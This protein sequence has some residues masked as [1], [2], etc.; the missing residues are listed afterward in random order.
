[1]V[2]RTIYIDFDG[3]L[4]SNTSGYLGPDVIPDPPVIDPKTGRTAI[5]WLEE[6]VAHAE[7]FVNIYSP[8]SSQPKGIFAMRAWLRRHGL[9]DGTLD[10]INFPTQKGPA[11]LTIDDRGWC[12]DGSFISPDDILRFKPWYQRA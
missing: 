9:T 11:F 10:K 7:L 3:V 4:H 8:R 1:M 5:Q 6:L 12:F 2:Q